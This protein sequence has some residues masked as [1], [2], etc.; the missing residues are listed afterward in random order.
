MTRDV[1]ERPRPHGARRGS[2]T[3]VGAVVLA[4]CLLVGQVPASAQEPAPSTTGVPAPNIVPEPNSGAEPT[5]AGD[6]GGALQLL[7]LGL[8]VLAV[9]GAVTHLVRQ[10]R[11]S[12][13]PRS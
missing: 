13:H 9:A 1:C 11:R 10:S 6:R 5:E 2:Q 12:R 3:L 7:I 4:L 8:V